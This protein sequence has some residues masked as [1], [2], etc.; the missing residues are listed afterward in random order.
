MAQKDVGLAEKKAQLAGLVQAVQPQK[1]TFTGLKSPII[2][3]IVPI[4]ER[5]AWVLTTKGTWRVRLNQ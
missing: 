3:E 1:S 5:A 2:T 4:H